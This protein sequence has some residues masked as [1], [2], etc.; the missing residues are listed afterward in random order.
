MYQFNVPDMTCG[1]CA[2]TITKALKAADPKVRVEIDLTHRLV[3]VESALAQDKIAGQIAEA[4]Y[5]PTT[6]G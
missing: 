5:T 1:H 2:G 6:V 3:K 4:G